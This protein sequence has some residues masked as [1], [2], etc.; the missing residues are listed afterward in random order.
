MRCCRRS[1][2]RM[3]GVLAILLALFVAAGCGS[4]NDSGS[5]EPVRQGV[6]SQGAKPVAAAPGGSVKVR[7]GAD[8]ETL[9]P[10]RYGTTDAQTLI[11]GLYDRLLWLSPSG[12]LEPWLASS[13]TQTPTSVT[14]TIRDGATC[15]DGTPV[16]AD[17]VARSLQRLGSP[18]TA[19]PNAV[20]T[21]GLAGYDV[22][23]QGAR[24]TITTRMP[25]RDLLRSLAMPWAGIVC[26]AGLADEAA[27]AS[28][29]FGSGPYELT[30]VQRGREYV[31]TARR[32]YDWGPAG[33]TTTDG[34]FP[35]ELVFKPIAN[36]STAA[37]LLLNGEL[38]AGY[39]LS[40][41]FERL[42]GDPD[43]FHLG[44]V[45]LGVTFMLFNQA[46]GRVAQ[47]PA[48]R[49]ALSLAVDPAA[50]IK[51]ATLGEGERATSVVGSAMQCYDPATRDLLPTFDVEAAKQALADAGWK[52]GADGKLAKDGKPLTIRII[53]IP[54]QNSGPEYLQAAFNAIGADAKVTSTDFK[55]WIGTLFGSGDYDVTPFT[56]APPPLSPNVITPNLSGGAPPRGVNVGHVNNPAFTRA[57]MEA[58]GA[59]SDDAACAAW[60]KAQ[61]AVI[62]AND[63]LPLVDQRVN[64]FGNGVKFD[65]YNALSLDPITI[66]KTQ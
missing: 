18:R 25:W 41:D 20:Y 63:V 30:K 47:D 40:Q 44:V 33:M 50:Y 14:L 21:F 6:E 45:K 37:N 38:D 27:L 17:V 42:T 26:P 62:R 49:K 1:P 35:A 7:L 51:A 46:S 12:R 57:A 43:R 15:A 10:A 56:T 52:P 8:W 32:G 23:A 61:Q 2:A 58:S 24:V 28:K 54:Q 36:D 22:R 11:M 19:A 48:V 60:A 4:S 5:G 31:L 55:T 16:T 3:L 64:Y 34:G 39:I 59:A 9:D 65:A 53:G 66:R 29:S 13:W